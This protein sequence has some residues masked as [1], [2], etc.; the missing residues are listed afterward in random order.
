[1]RGRH[2]SFRRLTESPRAAAQRKGS[3]GMFENR[4]EFP[5][6]QKSK[7]E[8]ARTGCEEMARGSWRPSLDMRAKV[9]GSP[10]AAWTIQF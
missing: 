3:E 4:S 2:E 1:M 7:R 6:A 9:P 5:W 10:F 8:P